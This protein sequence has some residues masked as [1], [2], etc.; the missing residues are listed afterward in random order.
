VSR[1][2]S[3]GSFVFKLLAMLVTFL[4]VA[5]CLLGLRQHR[6]ELT[7]QSTRIFD[8]IRDRQH[9]LLDQRVEIA[10]RTNPWAINAALEQQGVNTGEAM[11]TR[12][13]QGKPAGAVTVPAIETD[14]VAPLLN[15]GHAGQSRP[16]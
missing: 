11:R 9:T 16:R 4:L 5:L 12:Q 7:A 13:M 14:L 2:A 6:L 10:R 3:F 1:D 15:N 8:T